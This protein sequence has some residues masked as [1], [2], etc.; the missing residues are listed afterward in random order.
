MQP[1]IPYTSTL[2]CTRYANIIVSQYLTSCIGKKAKTNTPAELNSAELP[3]S[4]TL[5][6]PLVKVKKK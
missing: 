3:L 1:F 4:S 2:C 6:T 5:I